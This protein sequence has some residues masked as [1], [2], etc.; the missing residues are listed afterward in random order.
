MKKLLAIMVAVSM[1]PFISVS[2]SADQRLFY[3]SVYGYFY[4]RTTV[5]DEGG[6]VTY[7]I[8]RSTTYTANGQAVPQIAAGTRAYINYEASPSVQTDNS[9]YNKESI[10][11]QN[12]ST[13]YVG[14]HVE[15][16]GFHAVFSSTHP[17]NDHY[18]QF[19][20]D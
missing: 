10:T 15:G 17:R 5:S 9:G 16:M 20:Y 19:S 11:D 4:G 12:G 18:T 6:M 8:I 13:S 7:R 1:V 2:A 14:K 3:D